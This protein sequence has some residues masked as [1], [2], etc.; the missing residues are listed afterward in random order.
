MHARGTR[1]CPRC[2]CIRALASPVNCAPAC[3]CAQRAGCSSTTARPVAPLPPHAQIGR[4]I[5]ATMAVPLGTMATMAALLGPMAD[6]HSPGPVPA[7]LLVPA[8]PPHQTLVSA[9]G[10][11][12]APTRWSSTLHPPSRRASTATI[13]P[14][15]A[16]RRR[17]RGFAAPTRCRR[18][19][20]GLRCR[21]PPGTLARQRGAAT[22][23]RGVRRGVGLLLD[24]S[25][26]GCLGA[27]AGGRLVAKGGIALGCASS[28]CVGG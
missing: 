18:R 1:V 28:Q 14:S 23:G 25:R 16:S 21:L 5:V 2:P 15:A 8:S 17:Y 27:P 20:C 12:P 22:V 10:R 4:M 9:G 24:A 26:S 6:R 11:R 13:R 3:P 7:S 19:R